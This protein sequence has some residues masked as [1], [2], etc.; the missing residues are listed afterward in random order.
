MSFE[1]VIEAEG[2][3]KDYKIYKKPKDRFLEVFN[4]RRFS[5]IEKFTALKGV[6]FKVKKGESIGIVGKNGAG[7]S[8]LLQ[9]ISGIIPPSSG[10]LKVNGRVSALLELGAGFNPEFTGR[11]NIVLSASIYGMDLEASSSKIQSII[12][13]SGVGD[14]IDQPVKTYSSGMY[15]RLAFAISSQMEPDILIVDEALSVGDIQFQNK[16]LKLISKLRSNGCTFIFVSHSPRMIELF[17]DRAIWIDGGV[18]KEDGEP[19]KVV[20]RFEN[21]M[22]GGL[23]AISAPAVVDENL[24][25][26]KAD[27]WVSITQDRHIEGLSSYR[28][29]ALS[30]NVDGRI[31]PLVLLDEVKNIVVSVELFL[32]EE[33]SLPLLGV[34]LFNDLHQP[35]VHFNSDNLELSLPSLGKGRHLVTFS[36]SIPKLRGGDYL[37]ALGLDDGVPGNSA[38]LTHVYDAWKFRYADDTMSPQ[39]GYVSLKK[40][41][42]TVQRV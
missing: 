9:I 1:Y 22:V 33:V 36:F 41:S 23:E 11:E 15:V 40:T 19:R 20:R 31:N 21:Y 10:S 14:F 5:S 39:A 30:I 25:S 24:K 28:F 3:T 35:I 16:C 2:L 4:L 32:E 8:T 17:C 12:E 18:V 37:L 38:V 29:D 7:K 6:D 27:E 34:G 13:F 26:S 42:I